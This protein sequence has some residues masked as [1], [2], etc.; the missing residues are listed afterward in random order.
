MTMFLAGLLPPV[1]SEELD[2]ACRQLIIDHHRWIHSFLPSVGRLPCI[3]GDI[4]DQVPCGQDTTSGSFGQKR[5]RLDQINLESQQFCRT[6]NMRCS[7][8]Q[9]VHI[10]MS[11]LPCPDN[12]RANPKRKFEQGPSG[13][14]YITWAKFHKNQRTPLLI[15]EN[16]PE[17]WYTLAPMISVHVPLESKHLHC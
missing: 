14:I 9:T 12:S 3:F 1:Q 4:L 7:L 16:V 6:H 10:D 5:R 13:V 11:G 8:Q 17:P 15:L 2:P